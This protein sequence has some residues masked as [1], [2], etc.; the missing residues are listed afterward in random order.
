MQGMPLGVRNA[1]ALIA[2]PP[3]HAILSVDPLNLA[4]GV[5]L[6]AIVIFMYIWGKKEDK[7][8]AE[9]LSVKDFLILLFSGPLIVGVFYVLGTYFP[10][11]V[12]T[13]TVITIALGTQGVYALWLLRHT[14]P[15]FDTEINELRVSSGDTRISI[16]V[17][18][19]LLAAATIVGGFLIIWSMDTFI[20]GCHFIEMRPC[21]TFEMLF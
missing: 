3:K 1:E 18:K 17:I 20:F 21:Y 10:K 13:Q 6:S 11:F 16:P 9:V 14:D 15:N 5:V 19:F 8:K 12:S 7:N 2:N 4:Y